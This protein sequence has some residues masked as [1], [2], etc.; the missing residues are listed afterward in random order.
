M[1]A[2]KPGKQWVFIESDLIDYLRKNYKKPCSISAASLR[3]TGLDS[4]ST[5]ERSA[6]RLAQ[7]I[8]GKRKNS[9]PLL[10]IVPGGKPD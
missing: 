7:A 1:P 8:A 3:T 9:K 6:S 10:A 4:S 5:G 2:A